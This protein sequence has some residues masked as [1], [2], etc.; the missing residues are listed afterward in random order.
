[1]G[2]ALL[3]ILLPCQQFVLVEGSLCCV[4]VCT[5][6]DIYYIYLAFLKSK[7]SH[8]LWFFILSVGKMIS[9]L[10]PLMKSA[11]K[12][13]EVEEDEPMAKQPRRRR[14][15]YSAMDEQLM[16]TPTE[17]SLLEVLTLQYAVYSPAHNS[18]YNDRT[19]IW[20]C[21]LCSYPM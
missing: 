20:V 2:L 11:N 7:H 6:G 1:M 9:N 4:I 13:E 10:S 15:L 19:S 21:L 16:A 14:K 18:L 17:V 5:F 3:V 12:K 8:A